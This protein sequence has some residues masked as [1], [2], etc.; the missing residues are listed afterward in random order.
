MDEKNY[1]NKLNSLKL[2]RIKLAKVEN[3]KTYKVLT[4]YGG[5]NGSG[6][7]KV[8][9]TQIRSIVEAFDG[10]I[11]DLVNDCLDD[12]WTLRIGTIQ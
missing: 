12:V 4:I 11:V 3:K 9:L 1:E 10:W 6:D 8:Y 7:W 2:A 5:F